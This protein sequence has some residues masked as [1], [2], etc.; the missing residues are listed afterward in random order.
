[1]VVKGTIGSCPALFRFRLGGAK[2]GASDHGLD[3]INT[4]VRSSSSGFKD[5]DRWTRGIPNAPLS[6]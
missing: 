6:H 3:G 5:I 2:D 1:V 4:Q